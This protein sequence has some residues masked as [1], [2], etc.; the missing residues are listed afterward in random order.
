MDVLH[1]E[2]L[3]YYWRCLFSVLQLKVRYEWWVMV[4]KMHCSPFLISHLC[5]LTRITWKL[6]VVYGCC[7]YQ[8]TTILLETFNVWFRVAW[9]ILLESYGPQTRIGRSLI[10]NCVLILQ[11][12]TY[13]GIWSVTTHDNKTHTPYDCILHTKWWPYCQRCICC[14]AAKKEHKLRVKNF[15]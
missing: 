5:A 6:W 12:H 10:Q 15:L 2:W 1:I 7:A 3:L 14:Q 9:E 11:A 13:I 4:P 8:M